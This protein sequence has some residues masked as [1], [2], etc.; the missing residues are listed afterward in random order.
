MFVDDGFGHPKT[1]RKAGKM[2][3][4]QNLPRNPMRSIQIK[5]HEMGIKGLNLVMS[6]PFEGSSFQGCAQILAQFFPS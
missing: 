5:R 1:T 3:K 4:L 2:H 6:Q